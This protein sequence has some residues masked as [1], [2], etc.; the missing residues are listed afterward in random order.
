MD[1]ILAKNNLN[2]LLDNSE[3]KK[4]LLNTLNIL[5]ENKNLTEKAFEI[6]DKNAKKEKISSFF[7]KTGGILAGGGLIVVGGTL[8]LSGTAPI[9]GATLALAAAL[10]YGKAI[11]DM[12][13][14]NA[15]LHNQIN[16]AELAH[17]DSEISGTFFKNISELATDAILSGMQKKPDAEQ[18]MKNVLEKI[19]AVEL[20]SD[21]IKA[22]NYRSKEVINN[23]ESK[24]TS[25]IER[26][27][28]RIK[29]INND[30]PDVISENK[31][32]FK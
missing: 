28:S 19:K 30:N 20:A 17:R 13:S 31:F 7:K 9:L 26:F 24:N 27:K 25:M 15:K 3:F 12:M 14:P 16:Q 22:S 10:P 5:E 11:S 6:S 1:M 8:L 29:R 2:A 32:K 23:N 4:N 18:K 21:F